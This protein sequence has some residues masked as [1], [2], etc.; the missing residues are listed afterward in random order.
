MTRISGYRKGA[1]SVMRVTADGVFRAGGRSIATAIAVGIAMLP[2][3]GVTQSGIAAAEEESARE[4]IYVL[5]SI[6]EPR[7]SEEGWCSPDRTGFEPFATDAE[8]FF[9][10]WSLVL[11]ADDGRAVQTKDMRVADLRGCFGATTD[12]ARQNFYAEGHVG[13]T[14]FR[15]NGECH[16]IRTD[17]P[18]AGLTTVRCQLL[19]SGLRAPYVGG[20]L[21]SN[22]LTSQ[23]TFGGATI[24]P[25]YTQASIATIRLWKSE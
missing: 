11:R 16:A 12:R 1:Q 23:A 7:G 19:L 21:T 2:S 18:V 3:I 25:G 24:P 4:E 10:F 8:R 13:S 20:L 6:R 17:F 22:T 14:A 15:G 5:R 9:S